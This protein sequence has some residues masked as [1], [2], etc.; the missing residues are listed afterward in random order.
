MGKLC[1]GFE[2][3]ALWSCFNDTTSDAPN[4]PLGKD[5][6]SMQQPDEIVIQTNG[7]S[8]SY[9]NALALKSLDLS[10]RRNSIFGFLGPNGAGKT[11]T[12]KLL[13][14]LI[15]PTSGRAT[16][17]GK[18]IMRDSV[19]IRSHI[20]YLSQNPRF[21]EHLTARQI[22]RYSAGFYLKGPKDEIERRVAET[23]ELVGLS[24]IADRRTKDFSGGELQRV[25]IGQAQVHYPDLL[26]LDEPAASLDPVGRRDVLDVMDR[27]RKHTTVFYCTHILDD[28]QKVSDTVAI[29]NHGELVAHRPIE[30]LLAGSGDTV[31]SVTLKGDADNAYTRV[32]REPWV[33]EI[34]A[35]R[36]GELIKWLV[37]VTERD[38]AEEKLLPLLIAGEDVRVVSLGPREY[39]LEDVFLSIVEGR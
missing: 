10:V 30:E 12:I 5:V 32:S 3:F 7:L 27:L 8:K 6:T 19:T 29:L 4:E 17:F 20:G 38:I 39:E 9:K 36:N 22:L 31:Y 2:R 13:L 21:Y 18:D 35:S 14:G 37:S 16:V 26:I 28:V 33:S 23:L 15:F 34:K 11:T 1:T 24:D 25:G